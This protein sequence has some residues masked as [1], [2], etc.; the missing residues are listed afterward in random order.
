MN[1]YS[2]Q[3]KTTLRI[4]QNSSVNRPRCFSETE[5]QLLCRR[6]EPAPL[7]KFLG[8]SAIA[9]KAVMLDTEWE[10]PCSSLWGTEVGGA[11]EMTGHLACE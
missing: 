7:F 4:C 11:S 8:D 10:M 2:S 3:F 1:F 6:W 5:E 9:I